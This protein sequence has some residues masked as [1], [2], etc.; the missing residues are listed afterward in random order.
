[1]RQTLLMLCLAALAASAAAAARLPVVVADSESFEIVGR[2]ADGA[3]VLHVD[4]APDN[5]PV[6]GARLSV[7]SGG[8]SVDARFEPEEGVYRVSDPEWLRLLAAPGTYPLAFTL[9]AGD[10]GDLLAG[11]LVV[12]AATAADVS[13]ALPGWGWALSG[14]AL[15]GAGGLIWRRTRRNAR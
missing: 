1:M 3:L 10:D 4:R 8:R 11:D 13:R 15:A 2:I 7:E 14:L 9:L 12:E 5:S 6:F